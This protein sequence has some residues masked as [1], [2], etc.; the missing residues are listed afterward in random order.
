MSAT[1]YS[2]PYPAAQGD[3]TIL[4]P[5]GAWAMGETDPGTENMRRLQLDFG[6]G[7][8]RARDLLKIGR[9]IYADPD[10]VTGNFVVEKM[11]RLGGQKSGFRTTRGGVAL[12]GDDGW[13]F[14]YA[15]TH[16]G[17]GA[18]SGRAC[19]G[20]STSPPD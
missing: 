13:G 19:N 1:I 15:E 18:Q 16:A 12:G 6:N 10:P 9:V 2:D 17:R 5:Y 7:Q 8:Y 3:S 14:G 4:I 20:P 11:D